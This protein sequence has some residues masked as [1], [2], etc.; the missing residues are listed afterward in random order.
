MKKYFIGSFILLVIIEFLSRLELAY[1]Y[2]VAIFG[3]EQNAAICEDDEFE[4]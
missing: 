3:Q 2:P 4:L 1:A